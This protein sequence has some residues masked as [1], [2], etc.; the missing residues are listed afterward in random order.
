M[1]RKFRYDPKTDSVVEVTT[2]PQVADWKDLHC[3]AM[4]FDGNVQDAKRIDY[5]LGAPYVDYDAQNCPIF[6]DRQTYDK[7]LK[8]HGYVNKTSGKVSVID[9]AMLERAKERAKSVDRISV[10]PKLTASQRRR[11]NAQTQAEA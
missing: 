5:E 8:A 10:E 6:R 3:E 9:A 2:R 4:A 7:Y 11:L 1:S